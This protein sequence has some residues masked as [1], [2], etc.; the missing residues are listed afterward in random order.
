MKYNII[1]SVI[2]NEK[3]LHKEKGREFMKRTVWFNN[4]IEAVSILPRYK[5]AKLI[6]EIKTRIMHP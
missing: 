1:V 3:P 5:A 2:E 4:H 6:D